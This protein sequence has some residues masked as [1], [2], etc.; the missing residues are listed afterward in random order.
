MEGIG[1]K[2]C[3]EC[4]YG[5]YEE[6][7]Y[8]DPQIS[9]DQSGLICQKCD[10]CFYDWDKSIK[11]LKRNSDAVLDQAKELQKTGITGRYTSKFS[12]LDNIL[13]QVENI[14]D[15]SV[16]PEVEH[17]LEQFEA[18][19]GALN[20]QRQNVLA[21]QNLIEEIQ[22]ND[23]TLREKVRQFASRL[24]ALE[25]RIQI[26]QETI[27]R[28]AKN[29]PE[30]A[31]QQIET[32]QKKSRQAL[33]DAEILTDHN[34]PESKINQAKSLREEA[35]EIANARQNEFNQENAGFQ[36]T[37][38]SGLSAAK[39][40]TIGVLNEKICG[41][42]T[43]T[44]DPICGGAGCEFCGAKEGEELASPCQGSAT[45]AAQAAAMA[46]KA[47]DSLADKLKSSGTMLKKVKDANQKVELAQDKVSDTHTLAE[48]LNKRI[49]SKN[50]D[51]KKIIEKIKVF[52]MEKRDDP[53]TILSVASNVLDIPIPT[54]GEVADVVARL[55]KLANEIDNMSGQL[56]TGGGFGNEI[57]GRNLKIL[58]QNA[59]KTN[60]LF[61]SHVPHQTHR[62]QTTQR[63]VKFCRTLSQRRT[64]QNQ[65]RGKIH[66]RIRND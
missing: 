10:Q 38:E 47:K 49:G 14:L 39:E 8:A 34:D 45:Q 41:V 33:A 2:R 28:C 30:V 56:D 32:A 17:K 65:R 64:D 50:I 6:Y 18:L 21:E 31:A 26:M 19:R 13:E 57:W 51:I 46:K 66:S 60:L 25:N 48:K 12:A 52:L 58:P 54:E 15:E 43:E 40:I 59:P 3:D 36:A 29:T 53:D 11:E 4:A 61:P 23:N 27:Q 22:K 20:T 37:I 1:G 5:Y 16:S 55:E 63:L 44:C 7:L 62:S 9:E 24:E 42:N 35:E